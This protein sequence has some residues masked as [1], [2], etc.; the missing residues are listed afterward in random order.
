MAGK[1]LSPRMY[2]RYTYGLMN[3]VGGLLLRFQLSDRLSLET[4]TGEH[5]AM[6]LLYMVERE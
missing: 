3:R 6:D 4:R 5:K 2:M 1:Q